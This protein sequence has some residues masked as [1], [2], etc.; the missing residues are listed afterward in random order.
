[1]GG[2]MSEEL[3]FLVGGIGAAFVFN[4]VRVLVVV[5]KLWRDGD[6]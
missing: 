4:V 1:M 5:W 6:L 3:Q 2:A